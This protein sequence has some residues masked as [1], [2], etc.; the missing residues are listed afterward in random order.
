LTPR[1]NNN[2]YAKRRQ[3]RILFCSG[4]ISK[5]FSAFLPVTMIVKKPDPNIYFVKIMNSL[6]L[7]MSSEGKCIICGTSNK[8]GYYPMLLVKENTK[9]TDD[10]RKF[11][12]CH[13]DCHP[14]AKC[15]LAKKG[16]GLFNGKHIFC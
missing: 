5:L 16:Y 1:I 2:S 10:P 13:F 9:I 6:L 8:N 3:S 4:V 7:T 14:C 11:P 15:G 12:F